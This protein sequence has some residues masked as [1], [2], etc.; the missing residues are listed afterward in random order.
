MPLVAASTASTRRGGQRLQ[1]QIACGVTPTAFASAAGPPTTSIACSSAAS[2][3]LAMRA[4]H[5]CFTSDVKYCLSGARAR[6][7]QGMLDAKE[8]AKRVRDAMDSANPPVTG[9]ELAEFCKVTP[10]AVSGW[11]KNGRVAKGHLNKIALKCG[12]PVNY[13]LDEEPDRKIKGG[14]NA[15]KPERIIDEPD[16]AILVRAWQDTTP[17]NRQTL[18]GL[19]RTLLHGHKSR[20]RSA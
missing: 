10:Q 14:S 17:E 19:A 3:F 4:F 8:V 16:F 2:F 6:Q 5:H 15:A 7:I 11:R 13:F 1:S 20:R 9:K 18:V 12:V